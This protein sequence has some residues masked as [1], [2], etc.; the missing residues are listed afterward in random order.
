M[1]IK[2]DKE[3]DILY[4]SFLENKII[5]SDEQK[6]GIIM[7]YD[8]DGNIVGLEILNATDK[9]GKPGNVTYEVAQ[10]ELNTV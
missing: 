2:Y 5:E 10:K 1:K 6:P 9:I 4:I 3:V 8:K 7:D